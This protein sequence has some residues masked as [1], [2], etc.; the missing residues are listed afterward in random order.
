MILTVTEFERPWLKLRA[1][2]ALGLPGEKLIRNWTDRGFVSVVD[3]NPGHRNLRLF[4]LKN[5]IEITFL[6]ELAVCGNPL[7]LAARLS[8]RATD[9][10]RALIDGTA[11]SVVPP[12]A[13]A[14]DWEDFKSEDDKFWFLYSVGE[15]GGI[16]GQFAKA[17]DVS[18]MMLGILRADPDAERMEKR[19]LPMD[20]LIS[21]VMVRFFE[22]LGNG[23][24]EAINLRYKA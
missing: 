4:S 22:A 2:A 5:A 9:R 8:Q 19:L 12:M 1:V 7:P 15:D 21:E 23:T 17:A 20:R 18:D 24:L 3:K 14:A 13:T 6:H 16:S 11:N 10:A